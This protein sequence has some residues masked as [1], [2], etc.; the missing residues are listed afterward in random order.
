MDVRCKYEKLTKL[1]IKNNL[2]I[3]TMESC[4]GGL[5]ASL[6]TDT[7]GASQILKGAYIA[8]S[9]EAKVM[10]GVPKD[11]IETYGVYSKET[12]CAMAKKCRE[13]FNA[14]IGIGITGSFGNVDP[15]NKDSVP[16][17]IHY[18]IA[19]DGEAIVKSAFLPAQPSRFDYKMYAAGLVVDDIFDFLNLKGINK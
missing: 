8:Y 15:A 18:S 14:D 1:L 7:D 10:A 2:S 9:N 16:G 12:A 6:L 19:F 4:T 11:I 13:A 17:Q 5:I 3:T